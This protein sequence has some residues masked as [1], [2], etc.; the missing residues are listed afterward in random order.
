MVFPIPTEPAAVVILVQNFVSTFLQNKKG[1][2]CYSCFVAHWWYF[3]V[4]RRCVLCEHCERLLGWIIFRP[5]L[6]LPL[7]CSVF[8]R[9]LSH[10]SST[11]PLA[12]LV[13]IPLLQLW[14]EGLGR[15]GFL[16][17][18]MEFGQFQL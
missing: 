10:T 6:K 18:R 12:E 11:S 1:L 17:L 13:G 2:F 9:P 15:L 4:G 14:Q 8:P 16:G 3:S 5:E 7:S